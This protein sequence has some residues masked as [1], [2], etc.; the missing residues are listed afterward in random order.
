M[1]GLNFFFAF[2]LVIII[3]DPVWE[4]VAGIFPYYW[5]YLAIE[6]MVITPDFGGYIMIGLV[7]EVL[8][9]GAA[10]RVF[11]RDLS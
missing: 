9:L 3:F 2:P 1:K 5:T 11:R 10:F 8:C 7:M 4:I 6:E